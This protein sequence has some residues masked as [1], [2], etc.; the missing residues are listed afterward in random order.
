MCQVGLS[1]VL[2]RGICF[3][4][5]SVYWYLRTSL[6]IKYLL[7]GIKECCVKRCTHSSS[8]CKVSIQKDDDD[9]LDLGLFT[10]DLC[11][12]YKS[13]LTDVMLKLF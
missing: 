5:F 9:R 13:V 1:F 2:I 12:D 8:V 7:M 11:R 4:V 6:V 3:S 10:D